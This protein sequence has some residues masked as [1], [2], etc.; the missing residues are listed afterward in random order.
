MSSFNQRT[1]SGKSTLR[2]SSIKILHKYSLLKN[3]KTVVLEIDHYSDVKFKNIYG[4][5]KIERLRKEKEDC[6]MRLKLYMHPKHIEELKHEQ[7]QY[8]EDEVLEYQ[9]YLKMTSQQFRNCYQQ[10]RNNSQTVGFPL[11][12]PGQLIKINYKRKIY[13]R[14]KHYDGD[15]LNHFSVSVTMNNLDMDYETLTN[16]LTIDYETLDKNLKDK[17]EAKETTFKDIG[18]IIIESY[19]SYCLRRKLIEFLESG[20]LLSECKAK[21][22]TGVR[23]TRILFSKG[24][25]HSDC[26]AS[27]QCANLYEVLTD[28]KI[29]KR[30]LDTMMNDDKQ[31]DIDDAMHMKFKMVD[32]EYYNEKI[33]ALSKRKRKKNINLLK[34]FK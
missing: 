33:E 10:I 7:I 18:S 30:K 4:V 13:Y 1:K 24:T 27:N 19:D 25:F 32:M 17:C 14:L 12:T 6:Y 34:M 22:V 8:G 5:V 9:H 15:S 29:R 11:F 20:G 28:F 16:N 26:I 3:G 2:S 31:D 23:Q 21:Q